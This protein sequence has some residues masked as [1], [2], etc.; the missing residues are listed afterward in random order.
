MSAAARTP[1][2]PCSAAP[3]ATNERP[4]HR[5]VA[6]QRDALTRQIT[7]ERQRPIQNATQLG[8]NNDDKLAGLAEAHANA[9]QELAWMNGE[10]EAPAMEASRSAI[11][12]TA[13]DQHLANGNN[14]QAITLFDQVQD[15]LAPD[16]R[17][18]LDEPVQVARNDQA[19]NQWIADRPEP[20]VRPCKSTPRR[21]RTC[22]PT[23]SYSS[24]P[25]SMQAIPLRRA[26]ASP[27]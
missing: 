8:H 10:P 15:Q 25:S 3:E 7:G 20:M 6:T 27:W 12:R 26:A 23:S 13:I 21:T 24:A 9:A 17:L 19:A 11:W 22:R 1:S 2:P 18:S 16:D 5:Y 4:L 14:P